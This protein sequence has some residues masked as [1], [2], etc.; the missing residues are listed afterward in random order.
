MISNGKALT[1]FIDTILNGQGFI[2]KKDTWYKHTEDCICFFTIG[3]SPY[4]GYYD[5][6]FGFFL[7]DINDSGTKYPAFYRCNLKIGLEFFADNELVKRV[8]NLEN[9]E[10]KNSERE[11]LITEMF[12]LYIIPFLNDVDSKAGVKSAVKKYDD[13]IYYLDS[14]AM[15]YLNLDPPDD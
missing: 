7:K 4:G 14:D 10:F 1:N 12:D 2:K 3:K 8:L 5:H 11:F 13:L 15:T 9:L 6:A